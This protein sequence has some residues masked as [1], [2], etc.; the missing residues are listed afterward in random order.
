LKASIDVVK[1]KVRDLSPDVQRI[2]LETATVDRI[3]S[4]VDYANQF[5][6]RSFKLSLN[7]EDAD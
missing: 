6:L 5:L 7:M 4:E 1:K 3:K 2:M